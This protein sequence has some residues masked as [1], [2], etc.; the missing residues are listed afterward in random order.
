MNKDRFKLITYQISITAPIA[1]TDK[2]AQN[3]LDQLEN[4]L[5]SADE[6][7]EEIIQDIINDELDDSD[8]L[9]IIW[10]S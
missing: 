10:T 2:Q 8:D 3:I 1:W 9:R 6:R 5:P 7:I 4:L